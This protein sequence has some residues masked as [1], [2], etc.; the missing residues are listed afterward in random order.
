MPERVLLVILSTPTLR[1]PPPTLGVVFPVN[2]LF[3]IVIVPP[4]LIAPPAL[5]FAATLPEKMQPVSV[6][7]PPLPMAP[8]PLKV[9]LLLE[10]VLLA[11]AAV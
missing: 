10:N 7:V 3:T 4:L 6:I 2:V 11:I 8:P 1:M 5:E 9:S